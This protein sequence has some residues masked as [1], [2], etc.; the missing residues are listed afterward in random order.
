MRALFGA[1][2]ALAV[3]LPLSAQ[4]VSPE[5]FTL[6]NGMKFLL[7][8]RTD[9][10]NVIAAG[11]VAKVGSVN[12]RP[13]ITGI[14]HFF[15]HMMFKGTNTIGTRDARKDADYRKRQKDVRD[16]INELTWRDQYARYFAGEIDDPWNP[17]NDTDELRTARA[18]LKTLMDAQQG[19][20][21]GDA[22]SS[23]KQALA[24]AN[25]DAEKG[26]IADEI[27]R[28]E[29]AQKDAASIVKDEFDTVYTK[30][31]GSGMNAFTSYDLTFYFITVPSNKFELWAWMESDRLAD[32]VFR[33]FYSER[34][35]VHEE[36][37]LRTEST[38]T[39]IYD[40]QFDAM[41][42]MSSGYSWPV[43]G[44]PSDLN[45][46]TI[47]EAMKYWNI[48]YRPNNLVGFVV[49]DFDP[50]EAK[51]TIE[52]Y[53]S[54]LRKGEME[55]PPVVTLEHPQVAEMR[56]V[57][58]VEAQPSVQVRYHT[59]P[60]GHKDS[61]ALDV[62]ASVLNG[63]TGRL[64]KSMVEGSGI[65]SS[66]AAAQDARKYA[67]AFSFTGETKGDATPARLEESWYAELKRL[68]DEPVS[69]FELQKVKNQ[70]AA[71]QYRRLQSNLFLMIQLG[72]YE[73]MSSWKDIN[74]ENAK[75][76]AVTAE[77]I[78]RVARTY[79]GERSRAVATYVRKAGAAPE[80]DAELAA[81]PAPMQAMARQALKQLE[82][83]KDPAMLRQQLA[84]MESQAAQVPP[85]MKPVFDFLRKKLEARLQQLESGTN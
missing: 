29:Q 40:E 26:R 59:V 30:N 58:E 15:E 33:E 3:A 57:A 4:Q 23:L 16:R 45:S 28:L 64:Y 9:Q 18:E 54:R 13:G 84:V 42:W 24:K 1:V 60:Y 38:P 52:R 41:F 27:A 39:G 35:V 43:I 62:M 53:F 72:M 12:E 47:E 36:R 48:Y 63:R 75:I 76:Q 71:D 55:P 17:E 79:F 83:M 50:A 25:D 11:W 5:V 67:G 80:A 20:L 37:R 19:K 73:S 82:S 32:S 14:S 66:A 74:T 81:L 65:A 2:A 49:G 69:E 51:A 21:E 22:I 56:M 70:A 34:D 10:P 46:Y 78:Q 68:Q 77:E 8:P 61:Y 44:W 31:G 6:D 7:L 85:Q